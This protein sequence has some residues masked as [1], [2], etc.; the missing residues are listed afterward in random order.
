MKKIVLF[1]FPVLLFSCSHSRHDSNNDELG[2]EETESTEDSVQS[3][4]EMIEVV[5]VE[6]GWYDGQLPQVK[7]K[8]K[9]ISGCP[10]DQSVEVRYQFIENDEVFDEGILYLHSQLHIEWDNGLTKTETYRSR[11][12]YPIGSTTHRVRAKICYSDNSI[13]WEGN[14]AQ[15]YIY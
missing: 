11:Y 3:F 7:I 5:S 6:T 12:G 10:I 4:S 2:K 13:I 15:R 14:I 9:N 8:Y 1:I